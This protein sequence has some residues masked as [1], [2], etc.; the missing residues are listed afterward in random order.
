MPA[1]VPDPPRSVLSANCV[2]CGGGVPIA[3]LGPQPACPSCRAVG[4]LPPELAAR[5]SAL[6]QGIRKRAA[7]EEQAVRRQIEGAAEGARLVALVH[8]VVWFILGIVAGGLLGSTDVRPEGV[9]VLRFLAVPPALPA[10]DQGSALPAIGWWLNFLVASGI[11]GTLCGTTLLYAA[12]RR[13]ARH[14]WPRPPLTPE[15]PPRCRCC[16]YPG[17]R[18]RVGGRVGVAV[19]RDAPARLTG[20]RHRG[21]ARSAPARATRSPP[22]SGS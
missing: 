18:G 14:A 17:R 20:G 13:L 4:T 2:T 16:A 19:T 1:S 11:A 9:P 15:S 10:D 12:A 21:P 3:I 5:V 6:A 22:G 8:G 7:R